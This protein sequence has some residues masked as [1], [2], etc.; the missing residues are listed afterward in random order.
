MAELWDVYDENR[1]QTGRFQ[2]RGKFMPPED[3][4]LAV[5]LW[6]FDSN[7]RVLMTRRHLSK[8]LGGLW[9]CTGGAVTAGEDTY[10]GALREAAEEIGVD[11]TKG[12]PGALMRQD[13]WRAKNEKDYSTFQDVYLF[14]RDIPLEEMTLQPEEVIGAKWVDRAEYEAMRQRGEAVPTR[15]DAY[16]LL[17]EYRAGKKIR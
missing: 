17:A 13:H 1:Q 10:Q 2:E 3:Y 9:E 12:E 16:D 8:L 5:M 15:Y 4:H 11:L 6:I 14:I 7:D